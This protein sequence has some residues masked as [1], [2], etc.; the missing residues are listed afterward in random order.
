MNQ[1]YIHF[2]LLWIATFFVWWLLK[3]ISAGSET[4]R[5]VPEWTA[6]G[7]IIGGVVG[8]ILLGSPINLIPI[9]GLI[10]GAAIGQLHGWLQLRVPQSAR[11]SSLVK[12]EKRDLNNPYSP[13]SVED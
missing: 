7:C 8:I 11:S 1:F 2:V 5:F 3:T 4:R 9:L 13:P 12:D 6:L 10:L